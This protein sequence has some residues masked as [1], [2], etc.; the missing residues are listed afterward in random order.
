MTEQF[1]HRPDVGPTF[2]QMCRERMP[3][4][5]R[6]G[7]FVNADTDGGLGN[8]PRYRL[9]MLVMTSRDTGPRVD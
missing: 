5:M 3:E 6:A 1:L 4:R 8:C 9:L 7:G 2:E